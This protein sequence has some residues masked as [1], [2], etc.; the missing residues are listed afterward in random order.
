MS[1]CSS[2]KQSSIFLTPSQTLSHSCNF[3]VMIHAVHPFSNSQKGNK[4]VLYFYDKI[5]I[6]NRTGQ[7]IT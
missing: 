6:N 4:N 5:K 1:N 2:F 7:K 3:A